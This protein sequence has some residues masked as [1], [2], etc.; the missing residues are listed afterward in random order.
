MT[1]KPN[2]IVISRSMSVAF[3]IGLIVQLVGI[4]AWAFTHDDDI[5]MRMT[6]IETASE[7]SRANQDRRLGRIEAKLDRLLERELS[8]N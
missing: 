2:G 6:K 7:M 8:A 3:L 5:N 1:D 4:C